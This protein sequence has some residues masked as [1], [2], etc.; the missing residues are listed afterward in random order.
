M[1]VT[2][3]ILFTVVMALATLTMCV[4]AL[5]TIRQDDLRR[6]VPTPPIP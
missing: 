4:V 5:R 6:A 1:A 3:L 2:G